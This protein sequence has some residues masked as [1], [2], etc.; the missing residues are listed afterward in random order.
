MEKNAVEKWKT[1]WNY[2]TRKNL[3]VQSS[4]IV[5]GWA[6]QITQNGM[7]NVLNSNEVARFIGAPIL[8]HTLCGSRGQARVIAFLLVTVAAIRIRSGM[9][10][11]SSYTTMHVAAAKHDSWQ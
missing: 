4:N 3:T 8:M 1:P 11:V 5:W 2:G 7:V 9:G 10:D 6:K